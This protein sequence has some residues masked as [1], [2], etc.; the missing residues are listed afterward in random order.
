MPRCISIIE[1]E[2][3]KDKTDAE[4]DRFQNDFLHPF[5]SRGLPLDVRKLYVLGDALRGCCAY[6]GCGG[7]IIDCVDMR[8][9]MAA[10]SYWRGTAARLSVEPRNL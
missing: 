6:G 9:S 8:S 10:S 2:W 7:T 5:E 3:A 4:A 1:P